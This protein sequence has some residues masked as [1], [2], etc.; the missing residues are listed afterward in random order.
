MPIGINT[1]KINWDMQSTS[2]FSIG[3]TITI[4]IAL[5]QEKC[6][7]KSHRNFISQLLNDQVI[8]P[9]HL[10]QL[11]PNPRILKTWPCKKRGMGWSPTAEIPQIMSFRLKLCLFTFQMMPIGEIKQNSIRT[12]RTGQLWTVLKTWSNVVHRSL[13]DQKK[14]MLMDYMLASMYGEQDSYHDNPSIQM[15]KIGW[16]SC[17]APL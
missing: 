4:W 7:I 5:L 8:F 14:Q 6:Q 12:T 17:R 15:S 9:S 16:I 11:I 1:A 13:T 3:I 10:P 2:I